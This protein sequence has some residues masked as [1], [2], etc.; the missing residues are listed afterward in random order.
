MSLETLRPLIRKTGSTLSP[1]AFQHVVNVVFHDIEAGHYDALHSNMWDSLQQQINLLVDDLFAARPVAGNLHLLDIGSGT[2]LSTD[3]LMSSRLGKHISKITLLDTSPKMLQLAEE[4]VK[5]WN[6]PYELFNDEVAVLNGKFDVIIISSVLHHI[7]DLEAFLAKI[8][9]IQDTGGVLIHL[10]DP[11]GDYVSDPEYNRRSAEYKKL[12][13]Q[14]RQRSIKDFLPSGLVGLL[15]KI[16]GKKTYI[17]QVN[18]KLIEKKA[19]KK[20]MTANEIWSVTDIH[21]EDLPYSTGSGISVEFLKRELDHYEL[22]KQ[23]S[24][25]FFGFLKSELYPEYMAEEQR[26]ISENALNGRNV[27]AVWVK[28]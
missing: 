28:R 12:M 10:Q 25:G 24:Y 16:T 4:K 8:D 26:L 20:R 18:D 27:S 9:D 1:A 2:G 13:R 14:N 5:K 6:V 15:R 17:D 23:R 11:N 19:I 7:P 21:V 3:L 22:I